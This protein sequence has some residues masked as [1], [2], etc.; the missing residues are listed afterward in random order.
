[1]S[2]ANTPT[3]INLQ[4]RSDVGMGWYYNRS[5]RGLSTVVASVIL[6][7]AVAVMGTAIVAWSNSNLSSQ[8]LVLSTQLSTNVN[9]IKE[10][11]VIENVWF[12][13][14]APKIVNITLNNVG[15]VGFNVT[16]I[17]VGNHTHTHQT[18]TTNTA[19]LPGKTFSY[20]ITNYDWQNNS[21][22][23]VSITTAR[24]NVFSTED[25]P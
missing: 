9:K 11:L 20:N 1:M 7:A 15:T 21:T 5:S 12:Q 14:S 17:S 13:S 23:K 3:I 8:Q 6:L 22:I 25:A 24:G 19:V 4:R 10:N 18:E 2:F 16:Q